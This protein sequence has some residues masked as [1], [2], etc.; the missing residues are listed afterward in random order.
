MSR[1]SSLG[2]APFP[3]EKG[4]GETDTDLCCEMFFGWEVG[5]VLWVGAKSFF[6]GA[7]VFGILCV[8]QSGR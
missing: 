2:D 8:R 7:S 4:V 1:L 5:A 3:G 6:W